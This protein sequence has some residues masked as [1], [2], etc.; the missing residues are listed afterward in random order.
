MNKTRIDKN[1]ALFFIRIMKTGSNNF[2]QTKLRK[3]IEAHKKL[4]L[5]YFCTEYS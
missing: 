3:L 5:N 4:L 2:K 1:G